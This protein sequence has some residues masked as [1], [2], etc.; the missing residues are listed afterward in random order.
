MSAPTI[1]VIVPAMNEAANL[2]HVL[3]RIPSDVLEVILVDGDSSDD[4]V[5][6]ARAVLPSVRIVKQH[7]RGKGAALRT[8]F[9]AARGDII[10]MLDADGSTAPEEIP[11]FVRALTNGADFAKGSRFMAGGGT[12]DMQL[13]RKLGNATFVGMVRLLFGGH[14]TDLCYG[15]NAFWRSVVPQLALDGDGFEIETMMNV[16][17]LKIGLKVAEVPS[18]ESHRI[19]GE[20]NL[21]TIPDGMRVL[22]TIIRERVSGPVRS[23]APMP[24]PVVVLPVTG[25]PV[26]VAIERDGGMGVGWSDPAWVENG[27]ASTEALTAR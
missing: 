24:A 13:Y 18:F 8:G 20:S 14:Y 19:H 23:A 11:S 12:A 26:A 25:A 16:R 5:A 22:R 2:P 3:P 4:T 17:A 10:V 9:A 1:S 21:H 27:S 6:V 7:S 15:Y